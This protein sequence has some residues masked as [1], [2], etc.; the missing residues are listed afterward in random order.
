MQSAEQRL[1]TRSW[2]TP[3]FFGSRRKKW[4]VPNTSGSGPVRSRAARRAA[5]APGRCAPAVPGQWPRPAGRTP[6]SSP[7]PGREIECARHYGLLPA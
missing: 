2:W 5:H 6:G 1:E 3:N 4:H 7:P